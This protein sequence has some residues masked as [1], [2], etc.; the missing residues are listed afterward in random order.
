MFETIYAKNVIS[1]DILDY[2]IKDYYSRD[3]YSDPIMNKTSPGNSLPMLH[4]ICEQVF[5]RKL[6][7][8]TGNFYKHTQ[9]YLPHTD[10][11]TYLGNSINVV[12]PLTYT[13]SAPSLVIFDQT[14]EQDSVTW[15]MDHPVHYFEFNTGVK[16]CPYEYPVK[17]LTGKYI[18][19]ELYQ[20]INHYKHES[21][22]GLSGV[23]YSFEPGNIIVFDNRKIH[24]TSK[25]TG[26]KL[27]LS[28]R[29]K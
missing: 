9:P 1:K 2:C 8:I 7:Y 6:V 22:F 23:A 14:W 18:S 24:C 15:C 12:I 17:N 28:L 10:Y 20:Y 27:G 21:L 11:K 16:G 26:E 29:F 25:F 13:D 3:S 19:Q 4:A 5:G